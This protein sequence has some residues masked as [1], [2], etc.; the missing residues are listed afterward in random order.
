MSWLRYICIVL[1]A[2]VLATGAAH[3]QTTNAN[4]PWTEV[5]KLN[6]QFNGVGHIGNQAIIQI[7]AGYAFLG[8]S[9]TRH[10][11]ELNGNLPSD[12]S[13]TIGPKDLRWFAEF[14][15]E[16]SGHVSD[17]E[18]LD[19]DSL[20]DTLKT[21]NREQ[22]AE[23]KR[24]GLDPLIL[25]GWFVE[26]H[27]DLVTKR[28]EWGIRLRTASGQP[29]VNYT[30]KLLGRRGVMDAVLVSDPQSLDKDT[31]EFKSVLQGYSFSEG[32]R[33]TEFRPG[34]KVAEYGLSALIV[35]GAAA[36][37]VKTG[38]FKWLAKFIYVGV[39]ALIAGIG[40]FFR[41]LF[42]RK[43]SQKAGV[44]DNSSDA[45]HKAGESDNW[46]DAEKEAF[47]SALNKDRRV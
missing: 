21:H 4:D 33:Y 47:R 43:P 29:V 44:R 12:T 8:A 39:I 11:L 15:F 37:A 1:A 6:W 34:D 7:P 42:G 18:K 25:E 40:G 24:R 22:Q 17:S 45:E 14:D 3:A 20:L 38:A 2:F 23:M 27:Y 46:S 16:D 30:I 19:P 5:K 28:L 26:P 10:F 36:A 41:K 9:D 13:Y 32:E 35:G 31:R